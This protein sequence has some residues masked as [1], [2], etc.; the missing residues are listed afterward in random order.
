MNLLVVEPL[1]D[2]GLVELKDD[3]L[4]KLDLLAL[5]VL[6]VGPCMNPL[7]HRCRTTDLI[8]LPSDLC[9]E[10][11][12]LTCLNLIIA[13]S[14]SLDSRLLLLLLGRYDSVRGNV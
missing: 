13:L 11:L 2:V 1:L 7:S 5:H 9:L 12:V 4:L 14:S 6:D 3:L 10:E 8:V